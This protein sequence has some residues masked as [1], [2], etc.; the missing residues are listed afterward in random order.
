MTNDR[1]YKKAMSKEESI[2]ELKRCSGTQ[3]DPSIVEVF[4]EYLEKAA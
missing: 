4:L 2:K 1:V 3:F